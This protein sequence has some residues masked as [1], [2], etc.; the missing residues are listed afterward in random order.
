MPIDYVVRTKKGRPALL[1]S[2]APQAPVNL[3]GQPKRPPGTAMVTGAHFRR[4]RA[5][6]AVCS[7]EARLYFDR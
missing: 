2:A 6:F 7:R 5:Q 1:I 3:R 4:A